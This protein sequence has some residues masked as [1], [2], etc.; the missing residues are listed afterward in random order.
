[1]PSCREL[2]LNI[3]WQPSNPPRGATA[4]LLVCLLRMDER[5]A[6]SRRFRAHPPAGFHRFIGDSSTD[7]LKTGRF[8][9]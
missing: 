5:N 6:A 8:E 3:Y 7:S 2:P 1:M 4:F 9:T